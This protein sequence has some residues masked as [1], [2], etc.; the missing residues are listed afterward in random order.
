MAVY[1]LNVTDRR[2]SAVWR[3]QNSKFPPH[4]RICPATR[5]PS[6][7][8][9]VDQ[10]RQPGLHRKQGKCINYMKDTYFYRLVHS[11][12]SS[13]QRGRQADSPHAR[14][15]PFHAAAAHASAAALPNA[16][17]QSVLSPQL[18]RPGACKPGHTSISVWARWI[19]AVLIP[20][21]TRKPCHAG[22]GAKLLP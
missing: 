9:E 4:N 3:H 6:Q 22:T 20:S 18:Q 1:V 15:P 16:P 13:R 10:H 8:T 12:L 17:P 5:P 2:P 14:V 21:R 19:S 11:K 7:T